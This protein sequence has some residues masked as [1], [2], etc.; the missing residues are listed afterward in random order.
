MRGLTFIGFVWYTRL[1]FRCKL[2]DSWFKLEIP[3]CFD[4]MLPYQELS[5]FTHHSCSKRTVPKKRVNEWV[6]QTVL[7]W[8]LDQ[9]VIV[10]F[11]EWSELQLSSCR[12]G[13]SRGTWTFVLQRCLCEVWGSCGWEARPF[14]ILSNL[15][16][17]LIRQWTRI[18]CPSE[19]WGMKDS[20]DQ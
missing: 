5:R 20:S 9:T 6:S 8:D 10:L 19:A 3:S 13:Q 11:L 2:F 12:W 14:V 7:T 16:G 17:I 18:T 1:H 15:R 4:D